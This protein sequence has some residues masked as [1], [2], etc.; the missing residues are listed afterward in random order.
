MFWKQQYLIP[1]ILTASAVSERA[2]KGSRFIK[3]VLRRD[4]Y[5]S[6]SETG[7]NIELSW[8]TFV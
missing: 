4:S 8:E 1:K 6:D 2:S 7:M 5:S 3:K